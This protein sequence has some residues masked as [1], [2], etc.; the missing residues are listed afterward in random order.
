MMKILKEKLMTNGHY[1]ITA[2][3]SA[4]TLYLNK[5]YFK[6][7]LHKNSSTILSNESIY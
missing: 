6:K 7:L 4:N 5:R 1:T 3:S 2:K